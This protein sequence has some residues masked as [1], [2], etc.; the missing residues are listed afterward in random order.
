MR[1]GKWG[2][3]V[4]AMCAGTCVWCSQ[5]HAAAAGW[6][7]SGRYADGRA[8]PRPPF[9]L[10]RAC[11]PPRCAA[12]RRARSR[13]A[14]RPPPTHLAARRPG[15]PPWPPPTPAPKAR[16]LSSPP[17]CADQP[18]LAPSCSVRQVRRVPPAA[19]APHPAA[20]ARRA[21]RPA[22]CSTL[23][24]LSL[25]RRRR[26]ARCARRRGWRLSCPNWR[27]AQA[28]VQQ[29]GRRRLCPRQTRRQRSRQ[30]RQ[31][32]QK[33]SWQGPCRRGRC[34]HCTGAGDWLDAAGDA[35]RRGA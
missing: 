32:W 26:A 1:R 31:R 33:L 11:S 4:M 14:R 35:L 21:C 12:S 24:P 3:V 8:T 27:S 10:P 30:Q 23:R 28:W 5:D 6:R 2:F 25:L 9:P 22:H 20:P 17:R 19:L 7:S 29:Q 18:Q 13:P 16:P 34:R 15:L